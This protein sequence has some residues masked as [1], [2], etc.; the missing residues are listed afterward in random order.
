MYVQELV[1]LS[2]KVLE[3]RL[4]SINQKIHMLKRFWGG[5]PNDGVD[6]Q[7]RIYDKEVDLLKKALTIKGESESKEVN[8]VKVPSPVQKNLRN[9]LHRVPRKRLLKHRKQGKQ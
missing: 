1:K 9:R 8:E 3:E 7:L 6:R 5:I 2:T 4:D